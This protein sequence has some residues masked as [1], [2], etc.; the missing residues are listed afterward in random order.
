MKIGF[1]GFGSMAQAIVSGWRMKGQELE[2]RA[3][4]GHY[5]KLKENAE[6]MGVIP[7]KD[8]GEVVLHSDIIILAVKPDQMEEAV[9][10]VREL[11]NEKIVVSIAAG[12]TY[13]KFEQLCPEGTAHI[14]TIPNTPIGVAE[15]ILV[16]EEVHSLNKEQFEQ[17]QKAFESIS[18]IVLVDTEHVSIAGTIAGCAPAYTAMYIEALADAG[19][20]HGL[21]RDT[22]YELAAKMVVGTGALYLSTKKH[23]GAMKDEVCSPG[24]TTIRGVASLEKNAFRGIVIEAIDEVEEA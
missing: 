14:S 1:I 24:G 6:K 13:D 10:P 18:K 7:C 19:V 3:C 23:P 16:T 20:K 12:Y 22:A 5:E 9:Q 21:K 8:G 15:G 2:I 11:L 17:F 4:A